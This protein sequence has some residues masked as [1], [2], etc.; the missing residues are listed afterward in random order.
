MLQ[1]MI[2]FDM[3]APF[4]TPHEELYPAALEMAA[5]ADRSG[6]DVIMLSEHHGTE[7]GYCAAPVVLAAGLAARSRRIRLRWAAVLLP[8]HDPVA[9][10]EQIA[11]LDQ[12]SGG[13]AEIVL[14]A[15]YVPAEFAMF[16]ARLEDRATAVEER[17]ALIIRALEGE[18]IEHHGASFRVTPR[19]AQRPRPTVIMGGAVPAAA[20]RAARLT[21][22][23]YPTV[24]DEDLVALYEA[25][26]RALGQEPGPVINTSGPLFVHVTD[27]PE[28]AWAVIGPHALHELN[29]Y[30]RWAAEAAARGMQSPFEAVD[31]VEAAKQCGL[32]KVVTPDEC[33]ELCRRLEESGVVFVLHPLMG[34]LPPSFAW[35]SLEL[36][37]KKVLPELVTRG[38]MRV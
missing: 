29:A 26:C 38:A 21:D 2:R 20:R 27:D 9:V 35:E 19:P 32:Y 3:R 13:R 18:A 24:Y 1:T 23:F 33:L 8:L 34:G 16:G 12:V 30:G 22:G 10:A 36:F 25:E 37:E 5:W 15:G 28:K 6:I 7:D 11:V 31:D 14:G 17:T 4:E